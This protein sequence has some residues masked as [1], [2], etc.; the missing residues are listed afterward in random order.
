MSSFDPRGKTC[1]CGE[2]FTRTQFM[3]LPEL[4]NADR[5]PGL[6][7]RNCPRCHSTMCLPA[8]PLRPRPENTKGQ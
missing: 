6:A 7:M 4:S 5:Q 1:S 3:A 8:H 2:T